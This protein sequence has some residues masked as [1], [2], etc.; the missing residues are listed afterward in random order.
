ME[1]FNLYELQI[2]N[3]VELVQLRV[4][5]NPDKVAFTLLNNKGEEE[6]SLTYR[7]LDIYAQKIAQL[8]V[9]KQMTGERTLLLYPT[10][11]EFITAFLGCLYAKAIA[12]TAYP[13]RAN[14]SIHRI[15]GIA[16]S[17]RAKMILTTE[18]ILSKLQNRFKL[19]TELANLQMVA[20]SHNESITDFNFQF[21]SIEKNQIAYL[22]YT[23]GSTGTPKGVMIS[24]EN[25]L[26]TLEDMDRSWQHNEH[27]VM[28]TWLP[29]FHDMG[30]IYGLLQPIYNDFPCYV[31]SP[32]T[33][34]KKPLIWLEA[35]SKYKGTHS[36][37]PNFAYNHCLEKI[38]LEKREQL[39]LSHWRVAVNAAE[40]I[41]Y[42]T[43]EDFSKAF[44]ISGFQRKT[45]CPGFGLA[46]ATLKASSAIVNA[47]LVFAHLNGE[48]LTNNQVIEIDKDN[49]NV[50]HIANCGQ[51]AIGSKIV[52][53]HTESFTP[54]QE[55][56]VGE[57]WMSGASIAHGYWERPNATTET[58]EAYLSNGDGPFMRTG[59]L[60]FLSGGDL[61][62]TGRAKDLI[63]I[64]G[65]N[66]YPQDIEWTV[67]KAHPSLSIGSGVAF[68]IDKGEQEQLV[69]LQEVKRTALRSLNPNEVIAAIRQAIRLEH[70]LEAHAIVLLKPMR[71]LK[72]SSGKLQRK[73]CKKMFLENKLDPVGIDILQQSFTTPPSA[74]S[75]KTNKIHE[76]LSK[77]ETI[78]R[79]QLAKQLQCDTNEINLLQPVNEMG[80]DSL[81]L[82]E[83]IGRLEEQF[84][85]S[86]PIENLLESVSLRA[87]ANTIEEKIPRYQDQGKPALGEHPTILPIQESGSLPP[88]FCF[89]AGYGDVFALS[90]L[91]ERLGKEQ[92]FYCLQPPL[93][94]GKPVFERLDNLLEQY[95]QI[96]QTTIQSN[97]CIIG[98]YSCG[99]L[100]ALEVAKKLRTKGIEVEHL[101]LLDP[102]LRHSSISHGILPNG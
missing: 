44:K 101:I 39:D 93:L 91:A 1:T 59:D 36:A 49:P 35:I 96:I 65:R 87:L 23:S 57:I 70:E 73:A 32:M 78:V 79:N 43:V 61:Y 67:E 25:L 56:E 27:S 100:M 19:P 22:Q 30:L 11:M 17:S 95:V 38:T 51:S 9:K 98:G 21:T 20:T 46:E 74:S 53:V 42:N 31:M 72:T 54:C 68:S 66:H 63:I 102:P 48:A 8:L 90:Q 94:E 10:S 62:I 12:V 52:I 64:R 58:F 6:D 2:G 18:S 24:H 7:Q 88:F 83:W 86:I 75:P 29:I 47:P 45:F 69:V 4:R 85:V 33:F 99:G 60:G 76:P 80:L 81:S 41:Q 37:A 15:Q 89:N 40:P 50:R 14:R 26:A 82:V 5:Q 84:Q 77:I 97:N 92:P 16:T 71:V 34:S 55:N 13:P 3:L 28:V